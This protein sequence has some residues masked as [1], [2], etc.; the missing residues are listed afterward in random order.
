MQSRELIKDGEGGTVKAAGPVVIAPQ[1]V[2]HSEMAETQANLGTGRSEELLSDAESLHVALLG[3]QQIAALAK[4][5]AE[6]GSNQ[7]GFPVRAS[8]TKRGLVERAREKNRGIVQVPGK[9]SQRGVIVQTHRHVMFFAGQLVQI[10]GLDIVD[11]GTLYV[12]QTLLGHGH[13]QNNARH[14]ERQ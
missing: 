13:F 5:R 2:K 11:T 6:I 4:H 8:M 1:L 14:F 3:T 7:S 12:A 9:L 10:G